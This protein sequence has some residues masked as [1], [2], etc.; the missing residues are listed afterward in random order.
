MKSKPV[1]TIT[2]SIEDFLSQKKD[3]S[4]VQKTLEGNKEAFAELMT[5]HQKRVEI[6]GYNFFHNRADVDDFIQDVF[7]KVFN[8]LSSF[9]HES[10]FSTWLTRIAY[11]TAVNSKKRSHESAELEDETL[12]ES[13]Y[14]TP[15]EQHIRKIT[16]EAVKQALENLPEQYYNCLNLYF[17]QDMTYEEISVI[18]DIPLNTIKSHIFRAKKILQ[19]KLKSFTET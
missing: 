5:R 18:T 12:I 1:Q 14:Q 9:R 16:A 19:Q 17:F 15:E 13:N 3:N 11:T 7:I 8:S 10:K 4:L 2:R 6:M